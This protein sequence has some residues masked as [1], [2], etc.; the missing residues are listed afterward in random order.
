MR[1]E[2]GQPFLPPFSMVAGV[3]VDEAGNFVDL[4]YGPLSLSDPLQPGTVAY[5][6]YRITAS[7]SAYNA[8]IGADP[9]SN[10]A[11]N[12]V[13]YL[14]TPRPTIG[15]SPG[16][17]IGATQVGDPV[18]TPA[19]TSNITPALAMLGTLKPALIQ[20]S[21]NC[22]TRGKLAC[23]TATV[24]LLN[25]GKN[26]LT[27]TD[28][29]SSNATQ[30]SVASK[31]GTS[32]ER[33]GKCLITVTYHPQA[34]GLPG[35]ATLMVRDHSK[36]VANGAQIVTLRGAIQLSRRQHEAEQE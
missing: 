9:I 30:F 2:P 34:N 17:D 5:G 31:C 15:R 6:D 18:V 1:F 8:G 22:G 7:G 4:K 12:S 33:G 27:I 28:I 19:A 25:T 29:M 11:A 26:A 10:I 20:S 32:L 21:L 35:T 36:S 16:Y 23:G 24:Q 14:G 13:D 3:T